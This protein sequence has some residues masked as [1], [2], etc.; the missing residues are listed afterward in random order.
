MGVMKGIYLRLIRVF[1]L[2]G[3][4]SALPGETEIQ[5]SDEKTSTDNQETRA[6]DRLCAFIAHIFC[7]VRHGVQQSIQRQTDLNHFRAC[8]VRGMLFRFPPD[9]LPFCRGDGRAFLRQ[10]LHGRACHGKV[11]VETT[12]DRLD[13]FRLTVAAP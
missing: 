6:L 12:P 3:Y 1:S 4:P 13:T 10:E 11:L 8:V 5:E 2:T 7:H 9:S